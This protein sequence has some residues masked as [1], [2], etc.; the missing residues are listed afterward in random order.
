M[1]SDYTGIQPVS[2]FQVAHRIVLGKFLCCGVAGAS[3]AWLRDIQPHHL[4]TAAE[5]PSLRESPGARGKGFGHIP[6]RSK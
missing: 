2:H 1:V 3:V 6:S 5:G 4:R